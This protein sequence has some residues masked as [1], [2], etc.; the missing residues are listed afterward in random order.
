MRKL[1]VLVLM[2]SLLAGTAVL[3]YAQ[4]KKKAERA[5]PHDTTSSVI[6]GKKI[7]VEYGRPFKKGR[8]I[9]GGLVPWGKVWRAGADEA[10]VFTTGGDLMLG[11]LHVPAGS[12]SLFTIP[13]PEGWT[14]ILNK[15]VKQWGAY[16]YN[17]GQ[18]LGR[19]PMKVETRGNP[20]EQFTVL[21]EGTGGNDGVLKLAW[22][23]T[24]ASV[25]IMV[26]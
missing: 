17:Q 6:A 23:T 8:T 26:H 9:F 24:V 4:D 18:D 10:T 13:T 16:S 14:L 19:V 20:T 5:S 21:I 12:Y 11:R 15:T 22:D 2:A 25:P 3:A 1:T 7:S